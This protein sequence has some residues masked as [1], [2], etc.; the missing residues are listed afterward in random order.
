MT[1]LVLVTCS[2]VVTTLVLVT[3]ALIVATL[4]I[5]DNKC[6]ERKERDGA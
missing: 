5:V 4:C 1:S 6:L 3:C 2:L